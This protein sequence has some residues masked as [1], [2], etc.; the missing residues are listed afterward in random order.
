MTTEEH[1]QLQ[2]RLTALE[3]LL[4]VGYANWMAQMTEAHSEEFRR[5]FES[6][7]RTIWPLAASEV[8]AEIVRDAQGIAVRFWKKVRMRERGIREVRR[9]P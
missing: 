7:L 3:Q 9:N 5:Q 2:A 8:N 1:V 6:Q 4:E